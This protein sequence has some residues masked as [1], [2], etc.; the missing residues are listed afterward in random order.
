[1]AEQDMGDDVFEVD[2]SPI[3][4]AM[5]DEAVAPD[6][7][8]AKSRAFRTLVQGGAFAV[9]MAVA[10]AVAAL[11]GADV[12]WKLLGLTALQAGVTAVAS[13]IQK[14]MGK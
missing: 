14:V 13:Y 11:N 1:M 12:N 8:D 7:A 6:N 5:P 9:I 4:G 10:Q 2:E 3:A